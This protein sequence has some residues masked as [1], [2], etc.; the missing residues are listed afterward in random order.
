MSSAKRRPFCLGFNVLKEVPSSDADQA[1][2]QTLLFH[3]V[4]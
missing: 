2:Q 1:V 3:K 4:R